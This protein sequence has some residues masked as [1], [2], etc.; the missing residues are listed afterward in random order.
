[1]LV[2]KCN[3]TDQGIELLC[4][5]DSHLGKEVT[6]QMGDPGQCKSLR[7]LSIMET[8]VTQ[9]GV[10]R[11][12]QYLPHLEVL[13]HLHV[14]EALADIHQNLNGSTCPKYSLRKLLLLPSESSTT[15]VPF[16][17]RDLGLAASLCPFVTHLDLH[18]PNCVTDS[19]LQGLMSLDKICE[20]KL[21]VYGCIGNSLI[22]FD[23][24]VAPILKAKGS[25]LETIEFHSMLISVRLRSIVEYCPNLTRLKLQCSYS[26]S[27]SLEEEEDEPASRRNKRRK[28]DFV[29]ENLKELELNASGCFFIPLESLLLVLTSSP[30]L[31]QLSISN[32]KTLDDYAF[33][34]V[35]ECHSFCSLEELK[36]L[37]CHKFTKH[38]IDLFMNEQNALKTL[39]FSFCGSVRKTDVLKWRRKA[40]ANDWDIDVSGFQLQQR[41][42]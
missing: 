3:I 40:E 35:F 11:A 33:E 12:L 2:A 39:E 31:K 25:S 1:M 20:L 19:D 28:T 22:T 17:S 30:A 9:K 5:G 26:A 38:G 24:G 7:I 16:H 32:C 36:F 23:D 6:L 10:Q 13:D 34:R 8:G 18:I 4:G 29:W 15:F 37:N 27:A 14:T 21:S 41:L 42:Y